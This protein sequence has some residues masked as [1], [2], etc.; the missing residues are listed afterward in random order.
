MN[1]HKTINQMLREQNGNYQKAKIPEFDFEIIPAGIY[2]AILIKVKIVA[3][4][5]TATRDECLKLRWEVRIPENNKYLNKLTD[6]SGEH[7]KW[8]KLSLKICGIQLDALTELPAILESGKLE[9]LEVEINVKIDEYNG[10]KINNFYIK[11]LLKKDDE[12]DF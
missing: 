5:A 2:K 6:L 7:I 1:E 10:E 8:T 4:K 11:K 3:M 12:L 9:N